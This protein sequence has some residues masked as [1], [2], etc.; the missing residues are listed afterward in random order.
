MMTSSPGRIRCSLSAWL[1]P[2]V[3][4]FGTA[5]RALREE[6]R[7]LN[8]AGLGAAMLASLSPRERT[9][10]AKAAL[11]RAHRTPHQCC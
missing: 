2:V 5:T 8:S 7:R 3:A 4:A 10:M 6:L 1:D 11:E 9:R